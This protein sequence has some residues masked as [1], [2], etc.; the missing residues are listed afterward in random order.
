MLHHLVNMH[1]LFQCLLM[2]Q[3]VSCGG[4]YLQN[5]LMLHRVTS[6][7]AVFQTALSGAVEGFVQLLTYFLAPSNTCC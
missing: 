5:R 3:G 7:Q 2:T 4:V 6:L 1:L